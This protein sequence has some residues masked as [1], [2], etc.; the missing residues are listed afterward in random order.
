MNVLIFQE[1]RIWLK[2]IRRDFSSMNEVWNSWVDPENKGCR[3]CVE[4]E[5]ARPTILV[6]VQV[7]AAK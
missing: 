7:V 5:L 1:S 3:Y 4:A 6:E 2:N